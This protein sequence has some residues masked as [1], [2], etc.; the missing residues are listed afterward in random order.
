MTLI[1]IV[2]ICILTYVLFLKIKAYNKFH[3]SDPKNNL[4]RIL[5][6]VF[7]VCMII[8]ALTLIFSNI[9]AATLAIFVL[10][11]ISLFINLRT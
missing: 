9:L 1:N 7:I 6:M 2:S 3:R 10:S 4:M 5:F 8:G 11:L